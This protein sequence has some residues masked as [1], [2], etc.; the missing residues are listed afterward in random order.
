[1]SR[2][3]RFVVGVV[4][5]LGLVLAAGWF[6]S[7]VVAAGR[8]QM[9]VSFNIWDAE[10]PRLIGVLLLGASAC[11]IVGLGWKLR[12]IALGAAL[13]LIGAFFS[14]LEAL[15]I[16]L[17]VST[18]GAAPL[19]PDWLLQP[20]DELWLG[21][22]GPLGSAMVLGAVVFVVGASILVDGLRKSDPTTRDIQER[23]ATTEPYNRQPPQGE[24]P[25]TRG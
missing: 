18:S 25:G 1:M 9:G 16:G 24:E 11:A 8:R 4:A 13:V 23:R 19:L 5:I 17:G 6:D 2:T 21:V 12:S 3:A 14:L 10:V 22:T 15:V 7:T 20:L